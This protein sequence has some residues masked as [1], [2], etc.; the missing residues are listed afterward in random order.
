MSLFCLLTAAENYANDTFIVSVVQQPLCQFP[1]EFAVDFVR[2]VNNQLGIGTGSFTIQE[3]RI[4][5]KKIGIPSLTCFIFTSKD[6]S[7]KAAN[8]CLGIYMD[9]A[10]REYKDLPIQSLTTNLFLSSSGA[11]RLLSMY[12][13]NFGALTSQSEPSKHSKKDDQNGRGF[14]RR[15]SL[16]KSVPSLIDNSV[17]HDKPINK[18]RPNSKSHKKFKCIIM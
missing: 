6:Y 18:A 4:F 13:K 7:A 14:F 12:H 2:S 16:Q 11:V 5:Y 9:L 8:E 17:Q 1:K 3:Y 10:L 15:L